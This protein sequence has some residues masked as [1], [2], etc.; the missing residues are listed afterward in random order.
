MEL[1]LD[2]VVFEIPLT[3]IA[4]VTAGLCGAC[5]D[6]HRAITITA[7]HR[8]PMRHAFP[9]AVHSL[10]AG[11]FLPYPVWRP[12]AFRWATRKI[13]LVYFPWN[14]DVPV[15]HPRVTVLSN[16]HDVLPLII[17][18]Y[19]PTPDAEATYR[20][21]VQRDI[22]RTHVLFTDSDFSR[23][24]IVT[25]FNVRT[26]PIVIRFGPTIDVRSVRRTGMPEDERPFFLYVGGY[27]PRKGIETLLRV[28]LDLHR[29]HRLSARLILTGTPRYFSDAFRNLIENGKEQGIIEEAGYVDEVKLPDLYGRALALVYPSEFEGFGLP[30]IEAMTVGCPV[31][32]T[33]HTSLPEV[34]GDA[35]LYVEPGDHAEFGNALIAV[36]QNASLREDLR[37]RGYQQSKTFSW[38]QAAT[39]FLD[40]ISRTVRERQR[41]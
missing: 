9:A 41:L 1:L 5:L 2:A 22:D 4:K 37:T 20:R 32:T 30:P 13:P 39:V 18:G 3:G 16:V 25:N 27:D 6:Q 34:C 14:G 35:V 8:R 28:F 26:D 31:I 21:R 11:R 19:F 24:Q 36:E 29:E 7:L 38:N 10:S 40:A 33:R 23:R 12:L 17:P 15:L